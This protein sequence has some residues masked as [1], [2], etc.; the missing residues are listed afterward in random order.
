MGLELELK[1]TGNCIHRHPISSN[2][3]TCLVSFLFFFFFFSHPFLLSI[4]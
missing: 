2:N 4:L 1:K 3:L